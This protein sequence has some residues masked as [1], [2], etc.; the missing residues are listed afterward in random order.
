MPLQGTESEIKDVKLAFI[1]DDPAHCL[2]CVCVCVR[3]EHTHKDCHGGIKP[4][5]VFTAQPR[6]GNEERRKRSN[7]AAVNIKEGED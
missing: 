2:D 4:F 1:G 3:G 6:G 7:E 5:V